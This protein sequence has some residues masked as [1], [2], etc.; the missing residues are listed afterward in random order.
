MGNYAEEV[1]KLAD[2]IVSVGS[3]DDPRGLGALK[4]FH[5]PEGDPEEQEK[6]LARLSFEIGDLQ[7]LNHPAILKLLDG[8][9]LAVKPPFIVT[10]Y[11]P[12]GTL[13]ENLERFKGRALAALEAFRPLVDAV[14]ALHAKNAIHRDIKPKNIF[15]G[16][17]GRLVLGDFGIVFFKDA[18]DERWTGIYDRPGS[19]DWMAPWVNIEHRFTREEV[20][21]TLDIFSLGKVLWCMISG[22]HQL[23]LWYYK[24]AVQGSR[25]AN[26]LETLFPD[27]PAMPIINSLLAKC[28][29][30]EET[31]CLKTAAEL[32]T[33]VDQ[34][35]SNIRTLGEK[36]E[37]ST[38]WLCRV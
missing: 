19:R 27:D 37:G 25:S 24:K 5:L 10:G 31:A 38:S 26:N 8:S 9:H 6:T 23:Q 12:D 3:P 17:D 35:I 1:P 14:V 34:V 22:R 15:V 2:E 29:V 7:E 11:F 36:P 33:E 4:V 32:L 16:C 20:N 30:E 21:P 28:V 13:H 18:A